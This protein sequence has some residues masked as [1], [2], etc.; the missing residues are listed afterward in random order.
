[1]TK[2]IGVRFR[3]VG[4]IYYFS[5]GTLDI[6]VGDKVIVETSRG[7]EYGNVVLG[8]REVSDE[9]ISSPLKNVI[10]MASDEDSKNV[11]ENREKEKEALIAFMKTLS[12]K[13]FIEKK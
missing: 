1:M 2:I 8:V 13:D 5:P 10:R 3:E 4:K 7:L 6:K 12:D 9:S 11:S